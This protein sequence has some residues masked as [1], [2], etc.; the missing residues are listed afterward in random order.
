MSPGEVTKIIVVKIIFD[1]PLKNEF[2]SKKIQI[3][4]IVFLESTRG[5][6]IYLLAVSGNRY[7]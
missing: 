5:R 6:Y 3:G 4:R 2:L 1:E 7:E